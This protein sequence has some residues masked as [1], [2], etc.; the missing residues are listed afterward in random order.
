MLL[1]GTPPNR[2]KHATGSNRQFVRAM[3]FSLLQKAL[4]PWPRRSAPLLEINCGD[5]AFLRMLWRCGFDL[6][7]TEP[8]MRLRI[9][10]QN[11]PVPDCDIR[12]ARDDNLPFEEDSFDWAILHLR[13]RTKNSLDAAIREALRIARRG[14]MVTFWNQ[15]SLA[16]LLARMSSKKAASFPETVSW[17]MVWSSLRSTRARSVTTLST[18]CGPQFTWSGRSSLAA[19]NSWLSSFPVGAWCISRLDFGA[20]YPAT[21]LP[22]RF[23]KTL[24]QPQP[25]LE[26]AHKNLASKSGKS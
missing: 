6:V 11:R 22:L 16:A 8:D 24:P 21:P 2:E 25:A 15:Y 10:A 4:A 14:I 17:R 3:Q 19:I 26:Y 23:A 13:L 12:S 9:Q 18:L 20:R 7:A 1:S 5:G